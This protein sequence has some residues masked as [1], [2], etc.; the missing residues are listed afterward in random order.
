MFSLQL[1][2][3][4]R[5]VFGIQL[6]SS[7]KFYAFALKVFA[8]PI[9]LLLFTQT[10]NAQA[11]FHH[12]A[13]TSTGNSQ[14]LNSLTIPNFTVPTGFN[15]RILLVGVGIRQDN[16]T[17]EANFKTVQS[18]SYNGVNFITN[19]G[20]VG[21]VNKLSVPGGQKA[22]RVELWVLKAPAVGT[23]NVI[24]TLA[25]GQTAKF[26]VGVSLFYSVNQINTFRTQ[27]PFCAPGTGNEFASGIFVGESGDN[28]TGNGIADL[29]MRCEPDDMIVNAIAVDDTSE[30]NLIDTEPGFIP[31]TQFYID[32][33]N[34]GANGGGLGSSGYVVPD[35]ITCGVTAWKTTGNQP[36]AMIGVVLIGGTGPTAAKM[37]SFKA[38]QKDRQVK[39]DWQTA[40][41]INNLG[42]NIY[43]E[44]KG[45]RT[46]I[47][48]G[49]IAGSAL[50]VGANLKLESGS[51]YS[52]Y[53]QLPKKSKGVSYWLEE[54]DLN[55][56]R[57]WHGP[58]V[59]SADTTNSA[60]NKSD[61]ALLLSQL[62]ATHPAGTDLGR[63]YQLENKAN[64]VEISAAGIGGGQTPLAGKSAVKISVNKEGWYRVT[65]PQLV[66][67]GLSPN[68]EA[69]GLQLYVDG[70]EQPLIVN[71]GVNGEFNASAS[72]EFYG[73][74]LD[75]ASTDT[76][77]YWLVSSNNPG[78]RIQKVKSEGQVSTLSNFTYTAE[79][80]ERTIYFPGL[81][82]GD[83]ENFFGAIVSPAP[84]N[85]AITLGNIDFSSTAQAM[86][87]IVLQGVTAGA[88]RVLVQLN[89]NAI[90]EINFGDQ[91]PGTNKF[92]LPH[93]ALLAGANT[94]N[95]T[96]ANGNSDISLV[97]YIRVSYQHKFTADNDALKLTVSTRDK[98]TLNGF[99]SNAIRVFDITK[100]SDVQE[101]SG[102][103]GGS[104]GNFSISVAARQNGQRTLLAIT[105]AKA[106]NPSNLV[107]N[108][109]SNW[110]ASSNR[111][112]LIIL[113]HGN[114][115]AAAE[116]LKN[117]R[118]AEG[119]ATALVDVEDVY[120]EFSFGN[121]SPQAVKNFLNYANTS[122]QL[123]PRFVLFLGDASYDP[124]NYYGAGNSDFIPTKL[125]GVTQFETACDDWFADFND[126]GIPE[127]AVG[128]L[129]VNTAAGASNLAA[130][131]LNYPTNRPT[132]SALLVT[133]INDTFDF[134]Q[135]S[136]QINT[137]LQGQVSIEE[138]HRG[139]FSD[140]N[141]AKA[142]LLS[143]LNSGKG[144]VNYVGHGSVDLWR[145]PLFSNAE[146]SALTNT[147]HS[148]FVSTTCLNAYFH[149]PLAL[150]LGQALL[151]SPGGAIAVWSS[152]GL[153]TPEEQAV[154]NEEF[155]RQLF[156][157]SNIT[158]GEA[159]MRA[160]LVIFNKE[161]R[162][163]YILLGDPTLKVR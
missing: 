132:S 19:G 129:P 63:S 9:L 141:A 45:V 143:A 29:H 104:N 31:H 117:A 155:Y 12:S 72:I 62:A 61:E 161:V 81:L 91:S 79:L 156:G 118:Q 157:A 70:Q 86:L 67:A 120:D 69:K 154:I 49:L 42:Y 103:I 20:L 35:P 131:I 15:A 148:V 110:L 1:G 158:I 142:Q 33:S 84:V 147:R 50:K 54:V 128:R 96:A 130:K 3:C 127:M 38:V 83:A 37:D 116:Q 48:A 140:L 163:T 153:N 73:Q 14:G 80:R 53:D 144:F 150:S 93:S 151:E 145:G 100:A 4:N 30:P 8:L 55:G 94:I 34:F 87:E 112:D 85:Q 71:T 5:S 123:A 82:N 44:S 41:E 43:R 76:H 25:G 74:G 138:L 114:F 77:V 26:A 106:Q 23:G 92:V 65:Q 78:L 99:S 125:I 24:V 113:T 51:T 119:Y 40:D 101:L 7:T 66:A 121:K 102:T 160:K 39:I 58:M 107:A 105:N 57:F 64:L 11:A 32:S 115:Q 75:T 6:N 146:V 159:V 89:G 95:L 111:A 10:S 133:D 108:K 2:F 152:S 22:V 13:T 60:F 56:E 137:I 135:V 52:W 124:K 109:L 88:H 21:A 122:W 97:N 136:S 27:E 126:D 17:P 149:D 139:Q 47:N 68:V 162:R 36:Y 46:R 90:G 16:N 134:E 18:V 59:P 28:G 98:I